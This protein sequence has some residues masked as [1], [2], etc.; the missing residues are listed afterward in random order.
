LLLEGSRYLVHNV[1]DKDQTLVSPSF[2]GLEID[3]GE[4]FD[5]PLE[6]GEEPPAIHEPPAPR[7]RTASAH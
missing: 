1:F 7:Y 3:L 5:F 2:P 6:P 4:V